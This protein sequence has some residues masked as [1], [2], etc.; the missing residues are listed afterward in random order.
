[1]QYNT[2]VN[3]A[4]FYRLGGKT[5]PSLEEGMT[6]CP[7]HKSSMWFELIIN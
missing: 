3:H 7:K 6:P 2:K 1:M 5:H 4:R